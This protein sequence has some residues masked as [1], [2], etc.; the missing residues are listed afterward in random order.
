M[1]KKIQSVTEKEHYPENLEGDDVKWNFT[2]FLI[3]RDG[4]VQT[5][6]E[7][8]VTP[9]ELDSILDGIL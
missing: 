9:E 1:G 3:G 5:R 4:M 6:F 7:P 8:T 2:K